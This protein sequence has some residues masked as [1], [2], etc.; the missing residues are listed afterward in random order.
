MSFTVTD[1]PEAV[2][3][4]E[5]ILASEKAFS[6]GPYRSESVAG[7]PMSLLA[8]YARLAARHARF[9]ELEPG[10]WFADVVGLQG[11]WGDGTS[12]DEARAELEDAVL[13]WAALKLSL[14]VEVP[15]VDGVDV[16]PVR[17]V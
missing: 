16:N 11:V 5:S 17:S 8:E 10:Q 12:R 7:V 6:A 2:M 3:W 14:G 1:A 4:S 15:P 9:S 13:S